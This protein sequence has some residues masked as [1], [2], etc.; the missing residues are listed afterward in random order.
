MAGQVDRYASPCMMMSRSGK[1]AP[2]WETR[3]AGPVSGTSSRGVIAVAVPTTEP[4]GQPAGLA[5]YW[6]SGQAFCSVTRREGSAIGSC[7]PTFLIAASP[8]FCAIFT[9]SDA[10]W[11]LPLPAVAAVNDGWNGSPAQPATA[12]GLAAAT[13]APWALAIV[14]VIACSGCSWWVGHERWPVDRD[15]HSLY[16]QRHTVEDLWQRVAHDRQRARV[17]IDVDRGPEVTSSD[18][19]ISWFNDSRLH[20]N[21]GDRAPREIEELYACESQDNRTHIIREKT[22]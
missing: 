16:A 22:Y 19:Y 21:L 13:L 17:A 10:P 15:V 6:P 14:A 12:N 2:P 1:A 9:S 8:G 11:K 18:E 4:A 3:Y 7:V 20:E 5:A